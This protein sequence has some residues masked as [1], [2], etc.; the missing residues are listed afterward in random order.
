[1]EVIRKVKKLCICCME[2]HEVQIVR[3]QEQMNYKGMEV[4]YTAEYEYCE[5]ADEYVAEDDMI[6]RND[7]A[8]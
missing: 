5:K 6:S 8:Q 2:E 4:G 7:I 1:M 3:V